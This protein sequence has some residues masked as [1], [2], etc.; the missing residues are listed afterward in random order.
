MSRVGR[1]SNRG[2]EFPEAKSDIWP[3]VQ[4]SA[5]RSDATSG[6]DGDPGHAAWSLV[7]GETGGE[8]AQGIAKARRYSPNL[9]LVTQWFGET[10]RQFAGRVTSRIG[11]QRAMASVVLVCGESTCAAAIAARRDM[12]RR[13]LQA[14]QGIERATLTLMCPAQ[15]GRGVP[16]WVRGLESSVGVSRGAV[17]LI[18]ELTAPMAVR[19]ARVSALVCPEGD[20]P[21]SVSAA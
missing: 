15:P 7:V 9:K 13:C 5:R 10:P 4:D 3:R 12:L 6:A 17:E 14:M 19:K 11:R 16:A 2:I 20:N 1:S 8:W 21:D 18:V